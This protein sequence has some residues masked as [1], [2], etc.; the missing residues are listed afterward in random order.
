M[1]VRFDFASAARWNCINAAGELAPTSC[2][3]TSCNIVRVEEG[4]NPFDEGFSSVYELD[5][6]TGEL[7]SDGGYVTV[8]ITRERDE[9][10][11]D[12]YLE[13]GLGGLSFDAREY[14]IEGGVEGEDKEAFRCWP[15]TDEENQYHVRIF[16]LHH[17][18]AVFIAPTDAGLE[19]T[20][21]SFE[22][23]FGTID[24]FGDQVT[25]EIREY[26]R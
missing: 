18:G 23:H 4:L 1:P 12:I 26:A 11:G 9:A 17:I 24:C 22:H 13:I 21:W 5:V 6:E 16:D 8:D 25:P 7:W 10:T 19:L 2:C 20:D 3:R 15:I 14:P